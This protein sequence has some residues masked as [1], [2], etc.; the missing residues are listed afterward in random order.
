MQS[1]AHPA[2][3]TP[4]DE[5]LLKRT[6]AAGKVQRAATGLDQ[7]EDLQKRYKDLS[8]DIDLTG[9]R[10]R[11]MSEDILSDNIPALEKLAGVIDG[12]TE[13]FRMSSDSVPPLALLLR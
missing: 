11:V 10:L 1:E 12:I 13:K 5:A 3:W 8:T 6:L 7:S 2:S 4:P 9:A